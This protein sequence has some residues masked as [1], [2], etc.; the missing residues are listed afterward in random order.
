MALSPNPGDDITNWVKRVQF[1]LHESFEN[2]LRTVDQYPFQ[3]SESGWGEFEIVM[4]VFFVDPSEKPVTLFHHLKLY[5]T[6]DTELR[7]LTEVISEKYDE[8]V[9]RAKINGRPSNAHDYSRHF[10]VPGFQ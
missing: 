9:R 3:V 1:K 7:G 10:Y 8:I 2:H 6:G 5:N 4:K